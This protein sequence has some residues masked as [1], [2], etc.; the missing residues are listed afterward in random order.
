MLRDAMRNP[1]VK[2]TLQRDTFFSSEAAVGGTTLRENGHLH[3]NIPPKSPD[4]KVP[5][6]IP[7]R[8]PTTA[9]SSPTDP[10]SP[11]AKLIAPMST[12]RI[13]RKLYIQLMK[14]NGIHMIFLVGT[15]QKMTLY[16]LNVS[17]EDMFVVKDVIVVQSN[18]S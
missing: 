15:I 3:I 1:T 9:L 6:V 18:L 8:S 14:G 7:V 10:K 11:N 4:G 12:R 2:L 5:P 17:S 13:G 16:F